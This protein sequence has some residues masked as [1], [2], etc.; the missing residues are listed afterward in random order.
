MLTASVPAA[1]FGLQKYCERP[2][3]FT[4][5]GAQYFPV[6]LS[7]CA[8]I[9]FGTC[10]NSAMSHHSSP[11]GHHFKGY[12]QCSGKQFVDFYT[13]IVNDACHKAVSWIQTL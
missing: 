8:N 2:T 13:G 12:K 3:T 7:Q 11:C 1:C 9:A 5:L 4:T 6:P 10:Q